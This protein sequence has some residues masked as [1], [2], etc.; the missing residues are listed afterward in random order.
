MKRYVLDTDTVVDVLRGRSD[1]IRRLSQV[2]P[3]HIAVTSMSVAELQYRVGSTRDP[4]RDGLEVRRFLDEV[5]VL[6]FG[7][8][9]AA[10]HAAIRRSSR[11]M[12]HNDMVIAATA[13]AADATLVTTRPEFGRVPGLKVENWRD[14]S[15]N[16]STPR[17]RVLKNL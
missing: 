1:V 14:V 4:E 16:F 7:A 15:T 10:H 3:D 17:A 13:L 2:S 8:K 6:S 5:R 11:L 9:A 12:G